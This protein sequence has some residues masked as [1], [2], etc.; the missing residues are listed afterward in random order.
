MA[1]TV[2]GVLQVGGR[3]TAASNEGTERLSGNF[4]PSGLNSQAAASRSWNVGQL[5]GASLLS[6]R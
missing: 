5:R 1:G 4:L 3:V 6:I 2:S